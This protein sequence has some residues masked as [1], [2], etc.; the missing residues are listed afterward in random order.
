MYDCNT[1]DFNTLKVFLLDEKNITKVKG[2]EDKDI[3]QVSNVIFTFDCET[4]SYFITPDKKIIT[5]D[6]NKDSDFY[7]KCKKQG[8]MYIWMLGINSVVLYGRTYKELQKTLEKIHNIL[9]DIRFIV[10]VHNLSFDFHFLQNITTNWDIFARE[11]RKVM[12]A[13]NKEYNIEFR[14]SLF[15]T[16]KKL[17]VIAKELELESQ[18]QVGLLDYDKLRTP[19]T[20][21]TEEELKY[22]EYDI[23]VM[24][25]FLSIYKS[26]YKNVNKIPLT[27]TG[28]VRRQ[29]TRLFFKNQKHHQLIKDIYPNTIE[30]YNLL[31]QVYLGGYTHANY[32]NSN[33]TLKNIY[34]FDITS[35]YPFVCCVEKYPMTKFTKSTK[36]LS[37]IDREKYAYIIDVTFTDLEA[38]TSNTFLSKHNAKVNVVDKSTG[39]VKKDFIKGCVDDN[40]RVRKAEK[41]R[42]VLTDSDFEI[43]I[44]CY[45]FTSIKINN[46]WTAK[47]D[48]LPV[49]LINFVLRLFVEKTKYK[50]VKGMESRYRAAK[51]MLNS[52]Y[53]MLVTKL[54]TDDIIYS[55][56]VWEEHKITLEEGQEKLTKYCNKQ[57]NNLNYSWGV[58]VAAYARKNLW[59]LILKIGDEVVYCDTDSI[60]FKN[61][62][63]IKYFE[64]Y[65]KEVDFK[66]SKVCN[67]YYGDIDPS[68]FKPLKPNGKPSCL[69][70]FDEEP[71]YTLFKTLGAKKYCYCYEDKIPHITV[72]GINKE[73]GEKALTKVSDFKIGLKFDYDKAGK[74]ESYYND[75]QEEIEMPDGYIAKDK[76]GICLKKTTYLLGIT[77][78]YRDLIYSINDADFFNE[79]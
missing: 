76:Y 67:H 51:E 26:R 74:L 14:C 8:L 12:H 65:K 54:I 66:I 57:G 7:S 56:G 43:A 39:R 71:Y 40:G 28:E 31:K 35:S 75:D 10:Y 61:K 22:C 73:A 2:R 36:K 3:E 15:L 47:K 49:E 5:F 53:G 77:D 13:Y 50:D 11:Q 79:I 32:L 55:N 34:S 46:I 60:K 16:N 23:K 70:Y 63:N 4:T 62:D 44:K 64:D 69:G 9:Q 33:K 72:S 30:E 45:N 52:I 1:F 24:Y 19:I 48:Y 41:I 37:E 17:E 59:N 18:K 27:Q 58:W 21:L 29:I 38:K 42:Y 68:D 25:E 78:D 20:P 6:K